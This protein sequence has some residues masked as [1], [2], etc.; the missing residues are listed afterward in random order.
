MNS[1]EMAEV[2]TNELMRVACSELVLLTGKRITPARANASARLL[3]S[4]VELA[5]LEVAHHKLRPS[6]GAIVRPV[7]LVRNGKEVPALEDKSKNGR[8]K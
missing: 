1:V 2:T 3:M 5:N 6:R 4:V 7:T 8:R